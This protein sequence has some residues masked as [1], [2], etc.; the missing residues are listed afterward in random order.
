MKAF[1]KKVFDRSEIRF[2]IV[3]LINTIVGTS[4]MFISYNLL[5]FSYWLSSSLNYILA[6]ILSYF[7][8]KYFTFRSK[9]K[10]INELIKFAL[11][12]SICYLLAYGIAKPIIIFLFVGHSNSFIENIAMLLGMTMF[13]ILNYI[14]QRFFVFKEK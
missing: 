14:G 1:I 6:S 10:S 8:N 2:I 5:N 12:I 13:V 9:K 3:G 11:N 7:L 4:I